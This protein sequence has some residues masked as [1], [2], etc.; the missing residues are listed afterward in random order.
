MLII[1]GGRVKLI[2]FDTNKI[3][4]GHF[5]KRVMKGYFR[6]TP[7]EFRDGES[8]GTIPY[9]APEVLKRR[10]YGRACD[11]WSTGIVFFKLMTGRVPF[12]GKT[13]KLLRDRIV[14]AS[15]KWPRVTDHPH[16]ASAAAKDMVF[17]LLQ[18]NPIERLGSKQYRDVKTHVFFDNFNWD[19]LRVSKELCTI[20]AL[21][22]LMHGPVPL[23]EADKAAD[24]EKSRVKLSPGAATGTKAR[25]LLQIRDLVDIG[26]SMHRPLFT[27]ASP[28]FK[29]VVKMVKETEDPVSVD[30]SFMKASSTFSTELDYQKVTDA[31]S[32]HGL[33][34]LTPSS[35]DGK[36]RRAA[37]TVDVILFRKKSFGRFWNF[38]VNLEPVTGEGGR[39]FYIVRSVKRGTPAH[40]SQILEG[41]VVVA[42]NGTPVSELP[43]SVVRKIMDSAGD[44]LVLT[45]LSTSPFRIINTRQDMASI[46]KSVERQTM[47]LALVKSGCRGGAWFGFTTVEARTWDHRHKAF[48]RL[49]I[50]DRAK[51]V[52][53]QTRFRCLFPGDVLTHVEELPAS[54]M[55]QSKLCQALANAGPDLEITICPLSPLRRKRPSSTRLH[56]TFLSDES[57][58][59][60]S[61]V[62]NITD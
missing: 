50:V 42:V 33:T 15:L 2:D 28:T 3:C 30:D 7:F 46:L 9:M 8:A 51:D 22:E 25:R 21:S 39:N 11:W 57:A 6:R 1:P 58:D 16:S 49:H 61:S 32:T 20:P 29:R 59:E 37:E 19:K 18:K 35:N 14:A 31:D 34:G 40:R 55:S 26:R 52:S 60:P 5:T 56:E 44:Q 48:I 38:G 12:R 17:L 53:I 62:A 43:I 36:S 24:I 13:K 47:S 23:D 4:L 27:Y 41:D 54:Q 45:V 10:P